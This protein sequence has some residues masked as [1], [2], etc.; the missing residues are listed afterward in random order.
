MFFKQQPCLDQRAISGDQICFCTFVEG[1]R[2]YWAAYSSR[3]T[4][5]GVAIPTPAL[6]EPSVAAV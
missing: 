6:V 2:M 5:A 4:C 1:R 3:K